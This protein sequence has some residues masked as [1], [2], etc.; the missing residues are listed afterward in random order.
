MVRKGKVLL[1]ED[2]Q[3]MIRLYKTKFV[4]AGYEINVATDGAQGLKR[5]SSDP[6]DV[7]LL[8]IVMPGM[9]GFEVLRRLK[10]NPKTKDIPVLILTALPGNEEIIQKAAQLGAVDFV[11]KPDYTLEEM[12][13]K[14]R[15]VL[16]RKEKWRSL[17][18]S[19]VGVPSFSTKTEK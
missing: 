17:R 16:G 5:A 8:D 10:K 15:F 9:D 14:V 1:I 12:V 7:I 19:G 6:P 2:D 11:E 4:M 13:T 18:R 3:L